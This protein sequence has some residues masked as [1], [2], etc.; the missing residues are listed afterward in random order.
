M[1]SLALLT[2]VG[3]LGLPRSLW[4]EVS[5][6]IGGI[7]CENTSEACQWKMNGIACKNTQ[8]N[9]RWKFLWGF[10]VKLWQGYRRKFG[11]INFESAVEATR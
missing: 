1:L 10:H 2:Q 8:E 6:L 9:M 11:G 4:G 7:T 3:R 5:K